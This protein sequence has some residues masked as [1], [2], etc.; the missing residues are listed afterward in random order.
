MVPGFSGRLLGLG[1]TLWAPFV[2]EDFRFVDTG[3]SFNWFAPFNFAT[4]SVLPVVLPRLE[5]VVEHM[6]R[7]FEI[8]DAVPT[9]SA[10]ARWERETFEIYYRHYR[11]M[12]N[13]LR[14]GRAKLDWILNRGDDADF[15]RQVRVVAEDERANFVATEAWTGRNPGKI[16]NPCH[17]L[18][19]W[20]GEMWPSE[21]FHPDLLGP[22]RCSL[23]RLAC[24][25][26][27]G[28]IARLS[29]K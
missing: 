17:H 7:A 12:H 22:K 11:A 19:G 21:S 25:T 13:Y 5:T 4:E 18:T 9:I 23:E 1:L 6:R 14:L 29:V 2:L 8:I 24:F 27:S 20:L 3:H 15:E 10:R 16:S 28:D 26:V